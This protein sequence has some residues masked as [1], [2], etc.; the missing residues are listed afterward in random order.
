MAESADLTEEQTEK[1]LHFQVIWSFGLR[2]C[3]KQCSDR[4]PFG[5]KRRCYLLCS[6]EV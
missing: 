6:C 4:Y 2:Q 1:L 3:L 5:C